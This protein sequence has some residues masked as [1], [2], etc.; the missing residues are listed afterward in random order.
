MAEKRGITKGLC[1]VILAL[2]AAVPDPARADT[3]FNGGSGLFLTY[4]AETIA[5][6]EFRLG[7]YG[8]VIEYML[9]RDPKDWD[10]KPA[11]TYAPARNIELM[12]AIPLRAHERPEMEEQGIGDGFAGFK[13]RF[14]PL[15]AGL[16]YANLPFGDDDRGLGTGSTDLGLMAVFS[17]PLGAFRADLN[18]GYQFSGVSGNEA[19]DF[20]RY[21]LGL[22][23]Y[24]LFCCWR[25]H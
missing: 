11:F 16:V 18:A 14:H 9:Q 17:K 8:N 20:F 6:G 5:P 10:L 22:S 3:N 7:L 21:G 15:L 2:M 25:R 12:L 24:K 1:W 13:Y 23:G 4:S 19:D